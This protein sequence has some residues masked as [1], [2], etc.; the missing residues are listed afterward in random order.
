M[1]EK[2]ELDTNLVVYQ[3]TIDKYKKFKEN[4]KDLMTPVLNTYEIQEIERLE[5]IKDSLR[6]LIVYDT[7]Y[8]RNIQYDL[9]TLAHH[10]ESINPVSDLKL[11][12][13]ESLNETD[14]FSFEFEKYNGEHPA[15]KNFAG[16]VNIPVPLQEKWAE[17][18]VIGT[19]EDIYKS[20]L[21]IILIKAFNGKDLSSE[22]F[23][24]FNTL[25]KDS[26]GRKAW[27]MI[28][29][30][31]NKEIIDNGFELLGE[32]MISVLN[33]CERFIDIDT[34]KEN[35]KFSN[36]FCNSTGKKLAN[37]IKVHSI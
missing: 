15:F 7:S 3:E 14:T 28:L 12:I 31:K 26:V 18:P 23:Q 6:K 5:A 33:E 1:I 10:M 17:I 19:I 2:Q 35:L 8:I 37:L 32:L 30:R 21:E 36:Y 25:V 27:I 13:D 29:Q 9:D 11:V 20:E 24:Q 22:D 16:N 4:L 34:I